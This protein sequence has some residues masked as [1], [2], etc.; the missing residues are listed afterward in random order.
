MYDEGNYFLTFNDSAVEIYNTTSTRCKKMRIDGHFESGQE[1]H[2]VGGYNG[3]YN[4]IEFT[5]DGGNALDLDGFRCHAH[6]PHA[7]DFFMRFTG[8]G[9]T[10]KIHNA[11]LQIESLRSA[12]AEFFGGNSVGDV[13]IDGCIHTQEESKL[14]IDDIANF[15]GH[16]FLNDVANL[17]HGTG[18]YTVVDAEGT[19]YLIHPET[20]TVIYDGI[21]QAE[22]SGADVVMKVRGKGAGAVKLGN[23]NLINCLEI[24]SASDSNVNGVAITTSQTGIGP[25]IAPTGETNTD[26]K[27][28]GK[29]TGDVQIGNGSLAKAFAIDHTLAESYVPIRCMKYTVAGVPSASPEG[30]LIYVSDETGGEVLAFSDGTNWRRVTDRTIISA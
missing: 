29:G 20:K 24:I 18:T 16:L 19:A 1:D 15:N 13:S 26:F 11:D 25:V 10:F 8:L 23:D 2:P 14:N 6:Y 22:G 27:V 3:S 5:G 4:A 21:L 30:Q 28:R 7:T 9:T 12:G 17:T